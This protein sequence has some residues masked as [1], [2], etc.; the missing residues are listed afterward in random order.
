MVVRI[1]MDDAKGAIFPDPALWM[2]AFAMIFLDV[3]WLTFSDI[4]IMPMWA[5]AKSTFMT[6]AF[7]SAAI[8]CR[9]F[10]F[11][12]LSILFFTLAFFMAFGKSARVLNH[13]SASMGFPFIDHFLSKLDN[14]LGLDWFDYAKYINNHEMLRIMLWF[15]Y[16]IHE[17]LFTVVIAFLIV[18]GDFK[19]IHEFLVIF[20]ITVLVTL[21]F[22]ALFPALGT[23]A[24][25]NPGSEIIG[26]FPPDAGRYFVKHLYTLNTGALKTIDFTYMPGLVSMP[27]YHTI[28]AL[29]IIYA[30]RGTVMQPILLIPALLML[31][32]TPVYGGHY[33][34][35]ML[36]GAATFFFAVWLH[37]R[38]VEMRDGAPRTEILI[39]APKMPA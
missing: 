36:G 7:L 10:N 15:G 12:K 11:K 21:V 34:V 37:N 17:I 6:I 33:F 31:A 30:T 20:V 27:S 28:M 23:Y 19:R 24:Y 39:P 5:V 2:I 16:N 18:K 38:M 1:G 32:G 8:I 9:Y 14:S 13:L 29:M 25:Y 35:D 4:S 22:G 3:V 26:N